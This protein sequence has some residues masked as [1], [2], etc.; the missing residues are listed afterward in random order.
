MSTR[1]F[2]PADSTARS[3]GADA[4]AE[5]VA[6]ADPTIDLRRTGSRGLYWLEPLVEIETAAGRLGFG[7]LDAER[8]GRLFAAGAPAA[9]HPDCLGLV[10]ELPAL[11]VQQRLTLARV[12]LIEPLSLKQFE[13]HGGFAGLRRARALTPAEIVAEV[14]NSGLRGRGGAAFP[15]GV[16]WRTVLDAEGAQKYVVCNADEG[17][18]GTFADRMIM[19]SDPYLLIEGMCIAALAVGASRGYIYCRAEYPQAVANLSEAI[20][21]VEAAGHLDGFRLEVREGAGAYICGEE[22]SLLESLE[23]KRGMVRYRPPLPAIAGLFGKPTVMNNVISL[24]TAPIILARG[25]EH[26]RRFGVGRSLGTLTVQLSGNVRRGGLFEVPFGMTLRQV[27]EG[28]GGGTAS[29]RPIKAVQAGGPL[30]AY[31]PPKHFDTP[32][33]YESFQAIGAMIGH[34]GLVVFDDKADLGALA[35]YAL[36]FCAEESCGKCTPCR[37]G[38][39]RGVEVVDRIRNGEQAA[40]NRILLK[41]LCHTMID[42]SLCGLGGMAP[43]PVLS[44]MEHFAEEL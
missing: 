40:E 26:H 32:L 17:D 11:Q 21:L 29:G 33:D 36:E 7:P 14:T 39:V 35:R 15:T 38:A 6:A 42:G 22:T 12:G 10:E 4:V 37:I 2:V 28:L 30:G 1:V 43:L 9:D 24:A 19:E 5:A 16:K 3:L 23:G 20:R 31:I 27:L 41:D 8:A 34:G 25:A 44:V 13:H 18:S